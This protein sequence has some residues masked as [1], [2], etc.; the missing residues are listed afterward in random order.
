MTP[1]TIVDTPAPGNFFSRLA[2][3]YFSPGETFKDIGRAPKFLVPLLV[4]VIFTGAIAWIMA[5]RLGAA[6]IA[7]QGIEKAVTDGKMTAE[8]AAPQ[9]EAMKKNEIYIKASIPV[10]AILGT[11]LIVFAF[12]GILKLASM[13]VGTENTY[14][15]LVSVTTYANLAVGIISSLVF[16]ILLYLK[17]PDEFNI[18]NPIDSNLGSVLAMFMGK[19]GLPKFLMALA[20]WIDVFS[21]WKIVLLSIGFSAVSRRL[22]I[23]TA[24][25]V[26]IGLYVIAALIAAV[27]A[28]AF[29]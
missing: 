1:E 13:A 29:G 7:S 10:F 25:T 24:A 11:L 18:Q 6:R 27:W 9:L 3:V 19:D 21:I 23:G 2:G 14:S 8:Q 20:S 22:K 16:V 26:V 12:A 5:E 4:L 17:S 15:Q 28:S